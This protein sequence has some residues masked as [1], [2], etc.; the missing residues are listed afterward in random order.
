M[1]DRWK[2]DLESSGDFSVA[3]ARM[4]I[5]GKTLPEVGSR[6]RWVRYVPNKVNVHAWKVKTNGL[7]TRFNVSRR[8][9]DINSLSC[10]ICD[11]GVETADHLFFSCSMARQVSR[12]IMRWWDISYEEF[13]SYKGWS[14]WLSRLR[15]PSKNKMML[16]GVFYVLWWHLWTFRNRKLFDAKISLKEVFYDEVVSMSFHW[17]RYRMT[18]IE[19]TQA[20]LQSDISSLKQDTLNFKSMMTEIFNAFKGQSS[21]T[22]SRSVPTTTLAILKVQQLLEENITHTATKEPPSHTEG[23]NDDIPLMR[24]N[25]ELEAMT[26]PS[27][28]KLTNT[29][30]EFPT[31]HDDVE[32]I[33]IGSPRPQPT[34]ITPPKD[35]NKPVR[36]PYKI[37]GKLYHITDDEIQEHFNKEEKLKKAAEEAKLLAM[38]KSELIKVVHEEA[39]K[40]GIDLKTLRSAKGGQEFKR[41]RM[42]R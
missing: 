32:I 8:G 33:L 22:P 3:S 15:L 9:I 2:W 35:P 36:I 27:T 26:S 7:A 38:T 17:C 20:A 31:F 18:S 40:A 37:H 13:D 23:D 6:T 29:V 4:L 28:V 41:Y 19:S 16:E 21:S 11:N 10:G 5:D 12:L 25:P 42:L 14:D 30:L 39:S 1:D 34:I 24:I